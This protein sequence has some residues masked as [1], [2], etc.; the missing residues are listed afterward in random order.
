MI[1]EVGFERAGEYAKYRTLFGTLSRG[2]RR[3][4]G[5]FN[6]FVRISLL[7][8]YQQRTFKTLP[9]GANGLTN[10]P[11]VGLYNGLS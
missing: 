11:R 9:G 8:P 2:S 6:Y 3:L 10:F 5:G 7:R 4:Q 1:R